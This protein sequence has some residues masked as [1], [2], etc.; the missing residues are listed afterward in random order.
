[1]RLCPPWLEPRAD[2]GL[3]SRAHRTSHG[4]SVSAASRDML[5]S[6]PVC[7][8][9]PD[10]IVEYLP[11]SVTVQARHGHVVPNRGRSR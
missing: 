7:L 6:L 5:S 11:A 8:R 1:M 2:R 3:A 9:F 4:V 10:G